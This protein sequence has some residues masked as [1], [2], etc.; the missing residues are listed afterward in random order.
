M[1]ASCSDPS[2]TPSTAKQTSFLSSNPTSV[3]VTNRDG[4]SSISTSTLSIRVSFP[5]PPHKS[6]PP[7]K[8]PPA[9]PHS[10]PP[11]PIRAKTICSFWKPR[12]VP[13]KT[14]DPPRNSPSGREPTGRRSATR[15][16][17]PRICAAGWRKLPK[18]AKMAQFLKKWNRS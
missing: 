1:I 13:P 17:A 10:L 7:R 18:M 6:F 5:S 15:A 8:P 4:T 3:P 2:C 16:V 9:Q 14:G 12:H 11:L